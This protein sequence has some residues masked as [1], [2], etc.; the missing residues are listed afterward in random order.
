MNTR[1][2]MRTA[3]WIHA[4]LLMAL[5]STIRVPSRG[6][7]FMNVADAQGVNVLTR[8]DDFG[9]GI[10]FFD[11]DEDGWDDLS[12]TTRDDSLIF[13]RNNGG[14]LVRSRSF[15]FGAGETKHALWVDY[16]NDGDMDLTVTTWGGSYRLYAN[17]GE[18][19][20]TDVS[21]QV[22]LAQFAQNTYGA[23]WGDPDRDGDLDLYVCL[24]E[25]D[26]DT[27]VFARMN[28]FYRNNGDGTFTD[29]S[30]AAG[31]SDGV[32]MSFQAVWFDYNRDGWQDLYVLNDRWYS[33]S[34]YL[35]N[36]DGT[37]TDVAGPT[38]ARLTGEN[39]MTASVTDFDNDADLD[40]YMTNTGLFGQNAKLL[41]NLED[42]TFAE[43]A[44]DYGIDL[45]SWSWG[46][47]WV[48][49]DNDRWQDLYVTTGIAG[50]PSD[51]NHFYRNF[52]GIAFQEATEQ[53]VGDHVAK[54]YAVGRGDLD[55]DGY[56]D[57]AV[58]NKD[59]IPPFLWHNQGGTNNHITITLRGTASNRAAVG[60]WITVYA[61]GDR[62]TQYTFCG[63]NYISQNSQ[64][65]IFGLGAAT[66]VDSVRIEYVRGHADTYHSLPLNQRYT[67]TE[68][69]TYRV[70]VV[71]DGTLEFCQPSS[72]TLD[73]GEH[74]GYLWN[75]GDTGRYLT[76]ASSGS[77]WVLIT[78]PG[79][80]QV[81]TDSL[82]VV[83][84]PAPI[85]SATTLNPVC[86]GEE[87]GMIN[88]QD[89]TGTGGASVTW[90]TGATGAT[91]E[92]LSAGN[93]DYTYTDINGCSASGSIQ[94]TEPPA[95]FVQATTTPSS[96]ANGTLEVLVFGGVPPYLITLDGGP[97][98]P[99]VD[100]LDAGEYALVITDDQDCVY[101]EVISVALGT[102]V[103]ES[104][105]TALRVFPNPT[106]GRLTV[107][108]LD[109]LT[110]W[111]SDQE[112][113][114]VLRESAL[115]G[116]IDLSGLA[117]GAYGI[118]VEDRDGT[119]SQG[120]VILIDRP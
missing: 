6:Q 2:R 22:G 17:D 119:R 91:L 33:N 1:L 86:A 61:G 48:D 116:T 59:P 70:Q 95:L 103:Q 97:I 39:P 15:V 87:T 104:T 44:W 88:L 115:R 90:N 74:L 84:H 20:F 77:Y 76:V 72:V 27:T 8:G 99:Y 107:D 49:A 52:E 110:V 35:N 25:F 71:A 64:H 93:Y 111:I 85:I 4:V 37:F 53:F 51:S 73:A 40:I 113:R 50:G 65:H 58:Q 92:L 112:G 16:D 96:A 41:V 60:S 120:K 3:T 117:Q 23:S 24:Y 81:S 46:A 78:G 68:G 34:L 66:M 57:L 94:L 9:N 98:D 45:A 114:V 55:H 29:V 102:G 79:H 30:I 54:S 21:E 13:Y 28:H 42:G 43:R 32:K 101:E 5:F 56:Y 105:G 26:G 83:V 82:E 63:E 80:I 106:D 100:G 47:T 109:A 19:H 118:H 31:L 11:F 10:S 14:Q 12:F 36:T 69:E 67:F 62:Q 38:A 89:L 18:F 75:T 7:G 108:R